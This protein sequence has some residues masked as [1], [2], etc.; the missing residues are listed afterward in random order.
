MEEE[1]KEMKILMGKDRELY[2]QSEDG[3]QYYFWPL[4]YGVPVSFVI[5][6]EE[7]R[8]Q[9]KEKGKQR[10][11]EERYESTKRTHEREA[12]PWYKKLF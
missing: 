6:T 4:G 11:A 2:L 9:K 3:T 1:K 10:E 12:R 8:I 5:E 7:E